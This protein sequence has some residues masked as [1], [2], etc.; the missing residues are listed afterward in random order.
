[1]ALIGGSTNKYALTP[2]GM[3]KV[4]TTLQSV[5]AHTPGSLLI[6]PSRRTGYDNIAMLKA[7]FAGNDRVYI[8]DGTGDNPYPGLLAIAQTLIVTNDSVNMMTEAAAT[9]K[10]LYIIP[11]EGHA[12]TKPARFAEALIRDGIARPLSGRL[13]SWSYSV[14]NEMTDMVREI[15]QRLA[16]P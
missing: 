16:V 9:G 3:M 5:I 14:K 7:A 8:Y 15:R 6:T 12:D 11:L 1:V 4:I 2:Q 10:P 13:E